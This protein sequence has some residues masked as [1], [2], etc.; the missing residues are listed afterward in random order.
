MYKRN[1]NKKKK[2]NIEEI[3][4]SGRRRGSIFSKG[5]TMKKND[6]RSVSPNPTPKLNENS[7]ITDP[8]LF[9]KEVESLIQGFGGGYELDFGFKDQL[10]FG[11]GPRWGS[12]LNYI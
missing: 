4:N 2:F 3:V 12:V 5:K 10:R 6:V 1:R 9:K 11:E 8:Q 7:R